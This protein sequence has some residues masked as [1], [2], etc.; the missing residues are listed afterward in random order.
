MSSLS[1]ITNSANLTKSIE[2]NI[3]NSNAQSTLNNNNHIQHY[4][5]QQQQQNHH[6][7]QPGGGIVSHQQI[8]TNFIAAGH[9]QP[10]TNNRSQDR[11]TNMPKNEPVKLAYPTT[12]ASNIVTMNNNRVTFTTSQAPVQNGTITLSPMTANQLTQPNQQQQATV[13][14]Q[15]AG[16]QAPTLI[17]KNASSSA[18]GTL[19]S[20]PVTV[21]KANSQVRM[22]RKRKKY[23]CAVLFFSFVK[24]REEAKNYN[25]VALT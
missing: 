9:Q 24:R 19:I 4:N 17:F 1:S 22:R 20:T 8:F 23:K 10:T 2:T 25:L 21:T 12:Q 3:I 16:Q 6:Q 7:I 18:Q 15:R 11:L 14:Q 13:M 5:K